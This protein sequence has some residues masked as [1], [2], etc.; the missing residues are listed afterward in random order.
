MVTG[1]NAKKRDAPFSGRCLP[2]PAVSTLG[3]L[4]LCHSFAT[5]RGRGTTGNAVCPNLALD[6][7]LQLIGAS[8]H[9]SMGQWH[10][11]LYFDCKWKPAWPLPDALGVD[12][13]LTCIVDVTGKCDLSSWSQAIDEKWPMASSMWSSL[14]QSQHM[15]GDSISLR[16]LYS[17]FSA[18]S[19]AASLRNQLLRI[20]SLRLD[21]VF[22]Y[23]VGEKARTGSSR[24]ISMKWSADTPSCGPGQGHSCAA[25]VHYSKFRIGS[26]VDIGVA[27]D[28]GVAHGLPLHTCIISVPSN[29]AAIAPTMVG[30]HEYPYNIRS[31][32][33]RELRGDQG[34]PG[35]PG[36]TRGTIRGPKCR[37]PLKFRRPCVYT[38]MSGA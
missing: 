10:F 32:G 21:S 12:R 4:C 23:T 38:Q 11:V 25:Y 14:Q 28:K 8:S 16:D 37:R 35:G 6:L 29:F 27:H 34:G 5:H 24:R 26:P 7:L 36:R 33:T 9:A 3:L 20:I 22:A 15:D 17:A 31:G 19:N 1:K 2:S 13:K 18:N 30:H